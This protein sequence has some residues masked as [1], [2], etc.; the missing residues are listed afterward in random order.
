M[1]TSRVGVAEKRL[2]P[3]IDP[4]A[5]VW[6]TPGRG[7]GRGFEADLDGMGDLVAPDRAVWVYSAGELVVIVAGFAIGFDDKEDPT[8]VV[9]A[10]ESGG[11]DEPSRSGLNPAPEDG[12]SCGSI[13]YVLGTNECEWLGTAIRVG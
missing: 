4:L 9:D 3:G 13:G 8:G 5:T 11:R 7:P 2:L 6:L 1:S 10:D 12:S